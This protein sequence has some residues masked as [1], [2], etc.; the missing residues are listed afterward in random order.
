MTQHQ[1]LT[2]ATLAHIKKMIPEPQADDYY[3]IRVRQ[4]R[5]EALAVFAI[6]LCLSAAVIGGIVWLVTR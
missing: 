4:D 3:E 2:E 6:E 1:K 5:R